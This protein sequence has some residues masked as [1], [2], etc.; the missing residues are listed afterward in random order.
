VPETQA[1]TPETKE[2]EKDSPFVA[3]VKRQHANVA[4]A[5]EGVSFKSLEQAYPEPNHPLRKAHAAIMAKDYRAAEH[6]LSENQRL[7]HTRPLAEK[8]LSNYHELAMKCLLC[9][10]IIS[11][12]SQ[13]KQG[14]TFSERVELL[15]KIK[16]LNQHLDD[17]KRQRDGIPQEL[18]TEIKELAKF[19]TESNVLEQIKV[20]ISDL[21]K[22]TLLIAEKRNS[23]AIAA[24][25]ERTQQMHGPVETKPEESETS[26]GQ[27]ESAKKHSE[28][29]AGRR[30]GKWDEYVTSRRES[31]GPTP[32][33]TPSATCIQGA[34]ERRFKIR[35]I[36]EAYDARNP[37]AIVENIMSTCHQ[38][39]AD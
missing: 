30:N 10:D 21:I 20:K 16:E 7:S 33:Q 15:I 12:M 9:F 3:A 18:E 39:M 22:H 24:R 4:V 13:R 38:F 23:E 35:A 6:F 31:S 37:E 36:E 17:I 26:T 25:F 8:I 29:H 34:Q 14:L 11:E 19:I 32:K 27:V 1:E 2:V 28:D 5:E